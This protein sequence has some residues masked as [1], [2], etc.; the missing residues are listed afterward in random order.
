MP[1]SVTSPRSNSEPVDVTTVYYV[2]GFESVA[3]AVAETLFID[4]GALDEM[5]NVPDLATD[6]EFDVVAVLGADIGP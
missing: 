1:G 2:D 5:A 4:P 6:Q 3:A